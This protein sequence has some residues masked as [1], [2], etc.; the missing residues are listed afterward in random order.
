M[1]NAFDHFVM[2]L[3][4]DW[5]QHSAVVNKFIIQF[6]DLYTVKALPVF[7]VLWLLWFGDSTAAEYRPAILRGF[8][9]MFVAG[10][11]ARL[12]GD[13][14][15]ERVRPLHSGD[16]DF[17]PP[18]GVTLDAFERWSSFPS[19]HAAIFFALSTGLWLVSRR[20][21]A[22]FYAWSIFI[23]CLPRLFAGKHYASD[24]IA[25]AAIGIVITMVIARPIAAKLAPSVWAAEKK[26]HALFYAGFFALSYQFT[27]M[28]DD[29]RRT[30]SA[31]RKLFWTAL[32]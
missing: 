1:I 9:G 20:V 29:V 2:S 32:S 12:L 27:T 11:V 31:L 6:L 19:D 22:M 25:G 5:T 26:S 18:L 16:P 21:G 7:F 4:S 14:L 3:M 24:I 28:F 23:V 17:T 30:G 13:W 10:A 15:P 8:I